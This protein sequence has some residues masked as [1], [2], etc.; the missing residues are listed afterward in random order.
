[1]YVFSGIAGKMY[2][3]LGLKSQLVRRQQSYRKCVEST[4]ASHLKKGGDLQTFSRI[5]L[6][7]LYLI[8]KTTV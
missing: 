6:A 1:M 2:L 3:S 7:K 4:G 5:A 8:P